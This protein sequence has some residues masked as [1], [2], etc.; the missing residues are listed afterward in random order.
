MDIASQEIG[1]RKPINVFCCYAR[2]DTPYLVELRT[3]LMP[4]Q[5]SG[6]ITLWA[7]VD[8][9]AGAEWKKALRLYLNTAHIILLL[10]SADFL[11]SE[12]CYTME[13]QRALERHENGEAHVIPIII[14]FSSWQETPLG[15][16]QVLPKDGLPI[17]KW[18]D[19]D[20]AFHDVSE[21]LRGVVEAS[22]VVLEHRSNAEKAE[23]MRQ[24]EEEM[25][26]LAAEGKQFRDQEHGPV[27]TEKQVRKV[28][29]E[30]TH[31]VAD[32]HHRMKQAE[33][34]HTGKEEQR[35]H[36]IED[37]S[38]P[39]QRQT[40]QPVMPISFF[41]ST[42]VSPSIRSVQK[43]FA[44]NPITMQKT[45]ATVH[46]SRRTM[47]LIAA[48][49]TGGIAA[50]GG[51]TWWNL[52]PHPLYTYRGHA[53]AVDALARSPDSQRIASGSLDKT[54]QIWDATT[55]GNLYTYSDHAGS[56]YTVAWSPDGGL[57]ASGSS[58][59]TVRV[60]DSSTGRLV[61]TYHGQSGGIRTVAW[62]PDGKRIASAGEDK[63]VQVWDATTGENVH[64]YRSNTDV[65]YTVAW[66]PDGKR[67]ASAGHGG[68]GT[69]QVWDSST[70]VNVY[71]YHGH[72]WAVY[73]VT[74]FS[75]G[76]RIASGSY[77]KTVQIWNIDV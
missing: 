40:A 75:D 72:S 8:I 47:I 58:D 64:T 50:G 60:W 30:H 6:L 46:L 4:M 62:S 9:E 26:R 69:V 77:D 14:R 1:Q 49:T 34:T 37:H 76:K 5:R 56:V 35:Q 2:K 24:K 54:V 23:R 19:R 67:I 27:L 44:S 25:A 53:D 28:Q 66:S 41:P 48:A 32:K 38:L 74:W 52:F 61:Y 22:V 55:G 13:M 3:H 57:I 71:T 73:C 21:R 17:S 12:Y 59:G 31:R 63:T 43:K 51:I 70:G 42:A 10:V 11:A 39:M 45:A 16:L 33:P 68:N 7:D 15:K 36:N 65:V 20:E 18:H 29:E